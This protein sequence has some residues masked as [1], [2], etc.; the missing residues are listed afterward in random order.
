MQL[1]AAIVHEP[2]LLVLDEPFSGL[3]PVAV[4]TLA[5]VLTETEKA[6]SG[7]GVLFSSH[8]L[9]LVEHL[10]HSVAVINR[11]RL[12][13]AGTVEELTARGPRRLA[14]EVHGGQPD[15][16]AGGLNG[17][18]VMEAEGPRVHLQLDD[19]VDP[20]CWPQPSEPGPWCISPS[21]ADACP[22][23]SVKRWTHE[24]VTERARPGA[25]RRRSGDPRAGAG[26]S[27]W[28]TTDPMRTRSSVASPLPS[29]SLWASGP[30]CSRR[31]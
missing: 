29:P 25:P 4:D 24:P 10:C 1:A 14:V 23:S 8:Q 31:G 30:S 15:T 13:A 16:W 9:D 5:D 21:S 7:V 2:E 17:V 6:A 26:S 19:E 11:G 20:L 12:V 3:D 27:W 22:R 28:R 18:R